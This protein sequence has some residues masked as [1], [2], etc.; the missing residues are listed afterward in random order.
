MDKMNILSCS[1][2][3]ICSITEQKQQQKNNKKHTAAKFTIYCPPTQYQLMSPFRLHPR[4]QR[5]IHE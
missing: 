3:S 5:D 2:T 1:S 4:H